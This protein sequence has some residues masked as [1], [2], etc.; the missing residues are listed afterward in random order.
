MLPS[1][2]AGRLRLLPRPVAVATSAIRLERLRFFAI[3]PTAAGFFRRSRPRR[4]DQ[5]PRGI[6]QAPE[7]RRVM[8]PPSHTY[9]MTSESSKPLFWALRHCRTEKVL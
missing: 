1:I 4:V 2:C 5:T 8:L 6:V 7:E 9:T 3:V